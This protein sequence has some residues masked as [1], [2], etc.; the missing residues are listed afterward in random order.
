VD[1]ALGDLCEACA[2]EIRVRAARVARWVSL[3]TTL[4][5]A[6]YVMSVLPPLQVPRLVGAAATVTWFLVTRRITQRIVAE[7]L[8]SR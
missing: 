1:L 7:W 5:F 8:R 6:V 3:A 4:L 2:R